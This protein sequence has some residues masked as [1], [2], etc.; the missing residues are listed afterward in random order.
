MILPA[1]PR[2]R[3]E[4]V[5]DPDASPAD[6]DQALARFLLVYVRKH[7]RSTP[8]PAAEVEFPPDPEH[9]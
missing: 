2:D 4:V 1:D 3:F 9:A 5:P 6:W 8:A 7:S